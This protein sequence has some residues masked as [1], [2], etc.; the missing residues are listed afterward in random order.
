MSTGMEVGVGG[1][2]VNVGRT[3]AVSEGRIVG[4]AG[5]GVVTGGLAGP[6]DTARTSSRARMGAD[7]LMG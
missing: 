4:E 1:W 7:F 3:V 6:Q 2:T 5:T